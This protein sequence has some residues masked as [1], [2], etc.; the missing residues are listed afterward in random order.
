MPNNPVQI[1]L[2]DRDFHQAP[3]PGQPPRNKDFFEG[4]DKAFVTHKNSL[5]AAIDRII[6]E[7]RSSPYGPAAYLR[8]QMRNEAL[9]KSYRPVWWLFKSDQF[10]CV[11]ADAVGTLYFRSPLIYLKA[12][13]QRIEQ[14]EASVETKYRRADN[15]P[16]KAPTIA[17]AEVGAIEI[18]EIAPPEQKRAFSTATALAALEDPR[19]VSGY[20]VELFETPA[21]RVIADDPL[22]RIALRRS[23]ERLLLS[24]GLGARSYPRKRS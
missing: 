19:A 11:G 23:L 16:Y 1:I 14:A 9:A 4:A 15:K 8:V 5:L 6:D 18:I 20:Q 2:N 17:R 10:P 3:D 7:I 22:G 12:L 24:L 21:E 13:R